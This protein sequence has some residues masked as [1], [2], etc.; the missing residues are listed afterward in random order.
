MVFQVLGA[1]LN[2]YIDT[3]DNKGSNSFLSLGPSTFYSVAKKT[4]CLFQEPFF[5]LFKA[6]SE[7]GASR[8]PE[9]SLAS[10]TCSSDTLVEASAQSRP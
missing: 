4:I 7:T 2:A 3:G 5:S 10:C 8:L 1:T 9:G 6:A